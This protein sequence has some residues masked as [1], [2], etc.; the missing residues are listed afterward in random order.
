MDQDEELFF[1]SSRK[2]PRSRHSISS[3]SENSDADSASDGRET[4]ADGDDN[5]STAENDSDD[6]LHARRQRERS[7]TVD[8]RD[9]DDSEGASR[10]PNARNTKQIERTRELSLTPPPVPK[11]KWRAGKASSTKIPQPTASAA[12]QRTDT[13]N[14]D[15]TDDEH[16]AFVAASALTTPQTPKPASAAVSP[17]VAQKDPIDEIKIDCHVEGLLFA[18]DE[19]GDKDKWQQ[20]RRF[21]IKLGQRIQVIVEHVASTFRLARNDIAI[22]YKRAPVYSWTTARKLGIKEGESPLFELVM[23]RS[24][25]KLHERL[26]QENG[27]DNESSGQVRAQSPP[28]GDDPSIITIVLRFDSET[29]PVRV[30]PTTAIE[31]IEQVAFEKFGARTLVFDGERLEGTIADTELEHEDH[32]DV[33]R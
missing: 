19:I 21:R 5:S 14:I 33:M 22:T 27:D 13:I 2:R 26:P 6:E 32:V 16:D 8:L 12:A 23:R 7:R 29:M 18:G 1:I 17:E 24:L 9:D 11:T 20:R 3:G 28:A 4:D 25:D 10:S 31:R 30:K 15:D